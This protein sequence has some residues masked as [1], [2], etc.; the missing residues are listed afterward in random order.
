MKARESDS[1]PCSAEA[2][3]LCSGAV[4]SGSI[5]K[6]TECTSTTK[7]MEAARTDYKQPDCPQQEYGDGNAPERQLQHW[8][9]GGRWKQK[10][11]LYGKECTTDA[12][13]FILLPNGCELATPALYRYRNWGFRRQTCPRS[14]RWRSAQPQS[15]F[16]SQTL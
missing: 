4:A 13:S 12:S 6:A 16:I 15:R 2:Q 1:T 3:G 5:Y 9:K 7:A 10:Q 14:H 11:P 8:G